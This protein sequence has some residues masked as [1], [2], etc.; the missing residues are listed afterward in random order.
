[1][2]KNI[3]RR[4]AIRIGL[5]LALMLSVSAHAAEINRAAAKTINPCAAKTINPCAAKTINPCAAK[6]L[7]PCAAKTLNAAA[8]KTLNP[9]AAKTLNPCAAKTLNPCLAK[10]LSAKAAKTLN[11]CAAKAMNPCQAKAAGGKMAH[12]ACNPCGMKKKMNACNPCGMKKKMNA[13]NPCGMKMNPCN[14]CGGGASVDP[15]RFVQPSGTKLASGKH[16]KLVRKGKKLWNDSKLGNSGLACASCHINDTGMMNDT[17]AQSYPH[18]VQMPADQ[19][20]VKQVNAAEMVNFC[21]IVPMQGE[22]LAWDSKELAALTA[23][24]ESVQGKFK[25]GMG[26]GGGM[27]PCNPCGMKKMNPCNPCGMK[28]MN[29]CNPCGMKKMK[30]PCNPCS[31]K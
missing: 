29:P 1:M 10:S 21:M 27:N 30:N 12:N 9:C 19:A 16:S 13:C 8:A 5:S 4:S 22:P 15:A 17:F 7:N 6:T 25:P 2:R 20:G 26:G 14:P 18:F 23:Y 24:V 28:K 3:L 11:P 31:G